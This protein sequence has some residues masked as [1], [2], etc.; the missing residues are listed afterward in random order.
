MYSVKAKYL[1]MLGSLENKAIEEYKNSKN[2]TSKRDIG[3]KYANMIGEYESDCDSEI[4]S[5]LSSLNSQLHSINADTSIVSKLR[6]AYY[7]EKQSKKSY[8]LSQL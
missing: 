5:I 6:K 4:E 3:Y 1:S 7:E 2:G 8:Y